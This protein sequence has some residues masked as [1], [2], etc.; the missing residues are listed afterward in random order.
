MVFQRERQGPRSSNVGQRKNRGKGSGPLL[1]NFSVRRPA[2][3]SA[4]F[5][6]RPGQD[7]HLAAT[8]PLRSIRHGPSSS[9]SGRRLQ[10]RGPRCVRWPTEAAP[11]HPRCSASTRPQPQAPHAWS[12]RPEN[13]EKRARPS[14][15][16][17]RS[18]PPPCRSGFTRLHA[19]KAIGCPRDPAPAA[20][21]CAPYPLQG[22]RG[23]HKLAAPQE[24]CLACERLAVLSPRASP[25]Q[26]GHPRTSQKLARSTLSPAPHHR[27]SC[28]PVL[29]SFRSGD[30]TEPPRPQPSRPSTSVLH[31]SA[32][33]PR[34]R[35][36]RKSDPPVSASAL[37]LRCSPP[38]RRQR[39]PVQWVLTPWLCRS[40]CAPGPPVSG[41]SATPATRWSASA[42]PQRVLPKGSLPLECGPGADFPLTRK[43]VWP[44]AAWH[45]DGPRHPL[46]TLCQAATS[47]KV[48]RTPPDPRHTLD[49]NPPVP[50]PLDPRADQWVG[51]QSV[52]QRQS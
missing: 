46:P 28:S 42:T 17:T 31:S 39:V 2:P 6:R 45:R 7:A 33:L 18:A 49:A 9:R 3:S 40:G 15:A 48:H 20:S 13:H 16:G 4:P 19:G 1:P 12:P 8:L 47:Q 43:S 5:G 26:H 44:V 25:A 37:R 14:V 32:P 50:L 24:V 35:V 10:A 29:P 38:L 22:S 34:G 41:K 51:V 52:A 27:A 36:A 23:T 11:P 21:L 30:A